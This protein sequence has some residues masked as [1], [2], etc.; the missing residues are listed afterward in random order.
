MEADLEEGGLISRST[1]RFFKGRLLRK[2][3]ET[4]YKQ[5][6][7]NI[8]RENGGYV[9]VPLEILRGVDPKMAVELAR[10]AS[11]ATTDWVIS[12][13]PRIRGARR[14]GEV[15]TEISGDPDIDAQLRA[16]IKDLALRYA[17]GDLD[18]DS[19]VSERDRILAGI[20]GLNDE[21]FGKGIGFSDNI[22]EL[23]KSVKADIDHGLSME[24]VET[25][26]DK[27]ELR[28][29]FTRSSAESNIRRTALDKLSSKIN[30]T[31]L[32]GTFYASSALL[33]AGL[34]FSLT[35]R[36][37]QSGAS[38]ALRLTG[39]G[40]GAAGIIAG[41]TEYGV[42]KRE[43]NLVRQEK[44]YGY[45]KDTSANPMRARMERINYDALNASDQLDYLM[46]SLNENGELRDDMTDTEILELAGH[47]ERLKT[48]LE[49]ADTNKIDLFR[50]SSVAEAA[51]ERMELIYSLAATEVALQNR[52]NA[53]GDV[54]VIGADGNPQNIAI[55]TAVKGYMDASR[56][57][58]ESETE[59]NRTSHDSAYKKIMARRV[60]AAATVGVVSSVVAGVVMQETVAAVSD[61]MNGVFEQQ[62]PGVRNTLLTTLIQGEH[63]GSQSFKGSQ[64][65][66]EI[67]TAANGKT[68]IIDK[69]GT[70]LNF[71][72]P[73]GMEARFSQGSNT[74]DLVSTRTG[75]VIVSGV[76]FN[77][78]GAISPN[79]VKAIEDAGFVFGQKGTT[80]VG[81]PRSVGA[82]EFID[83]HEVKGDIET[84]RI[85]DFATNRIP[86]LTGDNN[87]LDMH[88]AGANGNWRTGSGA[89][90]IG[91][92]GLTQEGSWSGNK[93][94]NVPQ[95]LAEGRGKI[96]VTV[97][98]EFSPDGKY[99]TFL[100]D[101]VKDKNGK[102]W[103]AVIPKDHPISGWFGKGGSISDFHGPSLEQLQN[104]AVDYL[105]SRNSL[106]FV[107][108][109][110]VGSG[111]F[112]SISSIPGTGEGK[113]PIPTTEL[114][115]SAE[116]GGVAIATP[117]ETNPAFGPPIWQRRG[118]GAPD[119][120]P[121]TPP[122]PYERYYRGEYPSGDRHKDEIEDIKKE[123][124]PRI[125]E[126]KPLDL[127]TEGDWYVDQIDSLQG[128]EYKAEVMDLYNSTPEL[129]N[130]PPETK[131]LVIIP[132]GA[133]GESENIY[134]T[135]SMWA[136]QERTTKGDFSIVLAVNNI[137]GQGSD[138]GLAKK[139]QKTKAEIARAKKDFPNINIISFEFEISQELLAKRQSQPEGPGIIGDITRRLYDVSLIASTEHVKKDSSMSSD[140][141]L[142]RSDAD[143]YGLSPVYIDR[144]LK[145][146]EVMDGAHAFR[147]EKT[148]GINDTEIRKKLPG[149]VLSATF[150]AFRYRGNF[151]T[152]PEAIWLDGTAFAIKASSLAAISCMGKEGGRSGAGSD[153]VWLGDRIKAATSIGN[154]SARNAPIRAV[155][156]SIDSDPS[157]LI[158]RYMA[159]GFPL[160]GSAWR[161][162][163]ND[164]SGYRSREADKPDRIKK[165]TLRETCSRLSEF[166]SSEIKGMQ[167]P[168]AQVLL[169]RF[170]GRAD[171]C[172][173]TNETNGIR[174][175][176]TPE[177]QKYIEQVVDRNRRV[178]NNTRGYLTSRNRT[179]MRKAGNPKVKDIKR[180]LT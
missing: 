150:H 118:V 59:A 95:M 38:A 34:V 174:V 45:D 135:L 98:T 8:Q 7:E 142:I 123:L 97:N 46:S 131:A 52:I 55:G 78:S 70:S 66:V 136:R 83:W 139:I 31:R 17:H 102:G 28:G 12:D 164:P 108:E 79:S 69:P 103:H 90:R 49:L 147:A 125:K 14:S 122:T 155:G 157:R 163:D 68:A 126:G 51:N 74:F 58:S 24:R 21:L 4:R 114:A 20:D 30:K 178:L 176:F 39:I 162:F 86:G 54:I 22:I 116:I 63:N 60:A 67:L 71:A 168:D 109:E 25:A 101:V 156:A 43:A 29:G 180:W 87:E 23:A 40:A 15:E 120:E 138:P 32:G 175:N 119:K 9:E 16:A 93:T 56:A 73:D 110:P 81:P 92:N 121:D 141:L 171:V 85:V 132:V 133:V 80:I 170:F 2:F 167:I 62:Q 158:G 41:A 154:T 13:D 19:I 165:E 127:A 48:M 104:P 64:E 149:L 27:M 105:D 99:Q 5:E 161:D 82:Q 94:F 113:Y 137:E 18:D 143:I 96:M 130:L 76:E 115:F 33:A 6:Y 124:S 111:K 50:W 36:G 179:L 57:A 47:I 159:G 145:A 72:V 166:I 107:V 112:V 129:K 53:G 11:I 151:A 169:A 37:A 88:A 26:L 61:N 172:I 140:V 148:Y 75:N 65:V 89:I 100:F 84:T 177:G 128:Q 152:N 10:R 1:K 173:V 146:S 3:Y 35:E 44:A 106:A 160:D 117:G 153:D 77:D 134:K 91:I 42:V 144:M